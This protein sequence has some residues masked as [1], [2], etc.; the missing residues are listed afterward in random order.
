MLIYKK[1]RFLFLLPLF[2]CSTSKKLTT[3]KIITVAPSVVASKN[4]I[5]S[6]AIDYA[7]THIE[8]IKTIP[9][10]IDYKNDY[11]ENLFQDFK[12]NKYNLEET[13]HELASLENISAKLNYGTSDPDTIQNPLDIS[14]CKLPE[15]MTRGDVG[16]GFPRIANRMKS[17]GN[18]TINIVFV[19][20]SDAVST[21]TPQEVYSILT[22]YAE[23]YFKTVSYGKLNIQFK[24]NFKWNR[25]SKPSSEYGWNNLT[26]H[27]HKE[28]IQEAINLA[29]ADI[30]FSN[31]DAFIIIANPD[32]IELKNG[33]AFTAYPGAGITVDGKEFLSSATSGHDLKFWGGLWFNH[34]FGH[35]MSL[36]DLY[37]YQGSGHRFV[38]EYSIMG[39]ISCTGQDLFGWE[40][41][42][43]GWLNDDQVI[44]AN[45]GISTA[46]ITPIETAGGTKLFTMPI[47][48]TAAIVVESRR[49]IG[50]DKKLPKTG[51]LVYIVD[52]NIPSG[53][54]TIKILPFDETDTYKLESPM[55]VGQVIYY[56]NY[57]IKFISTD[58]KGDL[59][60][61]K[62]IDFN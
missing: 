26:F 54:G 52:T 13:S 16:I 27:L 42:I 21:M 18:L 53:T 30:D 12:S 57:S 37:A 32:A 29:D 41:W 2:A 48:N 59:I 20:F 14:N 10:T 22:P 56:M 9:K 45:S 55:V 11:T 44:C 43:L 5:N 36:V 39:L 34:E 1:Y 24:P 61:I 35:E 47:S 8:P 25:M 6:I 46:L 33:P 28:Y 40:K 3:T 62:R 17:L 49:A 15:M 31:S 58:I 51:P 4:T 19:D 23:D 50:Y 38:G 7:D 60:E